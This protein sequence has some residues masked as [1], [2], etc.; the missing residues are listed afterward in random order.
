MDTQQAI[1]EDKG[2][3]NQFVALDNKTREELLKEQQTNEAKELIQ[4]VKEIVLK[5][6]LPP[7]TPKSEEKSFIP[8]DYKKYLIVGGIGLTCFVLGALI[9]RKKK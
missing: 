7:A 9:F 1:S 8:E 2:S 4:K 6:N 3:E 5:M